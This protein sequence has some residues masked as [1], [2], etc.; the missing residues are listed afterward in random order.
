MYCIVIRYWMYNSI[1]VFI[2]NVSLIF[3]HISPSYLSFSTHEKWWDTFSVSFFLF[4]ETKSYFGIVVGLH[5]IC[6]DD[7]FYHDI[8]YGFN[9]YQ[10]YMKRLWLALTMYDDVGIEFPFL[11]TIFRELYV[12]RGGKHTHTHLVNNV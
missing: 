2:Q 12:T 11:Y 8:C 4:L 3:I 5:P 9:S 7:E 10:L 6:S 1:S